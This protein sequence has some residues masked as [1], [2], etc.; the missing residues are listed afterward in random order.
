MK[1][2]LIKQSKVKKT[3]Y[4]LFVGQSISHMTSVVNAYPNYTH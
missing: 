2:L 1:T 4:I 3:R